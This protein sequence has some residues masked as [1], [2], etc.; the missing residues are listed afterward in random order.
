MLS[1]ETPLDA[2]MIKMINNA[3]IFI[4][5]NSLLTFLSPYTMVF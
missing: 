5:I 1:F 2:L 4:K 3:Y